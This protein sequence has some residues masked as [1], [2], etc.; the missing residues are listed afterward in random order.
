MPDSAT[1][2]SPAATTSQEPSKR[3]AYTIRASGGFLAAN[4]GPSG[5]PIV[6][7]KDAIKATRFTESF[8]AHCRAAELEHLGWTDLT[9]APLE[10]PLLS[11]AVCPD[12]SN[13]PATTNSLNERK[14]TMRAKDLLSGPS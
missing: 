10:V 4:H 1:E 6:L 11:S 13:T 5:P 7:V 8:T 9:V 14:T 2:D 12:P 3:L